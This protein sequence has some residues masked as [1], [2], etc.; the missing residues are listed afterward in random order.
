MTNLTSIYNKLTLK[1]KIGLGSFLM[2]FI[3]W[4]FCLP[5]LLFDDPISTVVLSSDQVLVGARIAEDGQWRFPELDSVPYRFEQSVLFFEDEYFYQHPGFNPVSIFKA[6][7]HNLTKDSRR[8]GSTITQQLIRLSRK[9]KSRTYWEKG[10]ELFLATRL[11][12]RYSKED[13]LRLYASHT[14]Y[15]GNV[16][17]LE[18][19]A[20]RYFGIPAHELSWGQSATLAVLPNAPSLIFPGRN[21]QTLR[22]KRNRL[23]KKLWVKDVIDQTTYELAIAE[24]LPQKPL[25]LPNIAPHLTER[26][27]KEHP[28]KSITTSLDRPL[29][30]QTNSLAEQH[31]QRLKSN[32]IHNLAILV[33][34]VETRKVLAYVGNSPASGEHGNYVD[35]I[36]KNRSTGSTLKPF[37]FTS[38]L[39]EGQLLPN[40][41]VND[42]PTVINGYNPKNFNK[43][44]TGVVPASWALSRSLNV[45]AVR[46]LRQ[47]G[48]QKFYNKLQK[49]QMKSLDKP[50][51]YYG[52]SLILGGA[53]SS[54]WDVTKSY[55]SAASTL[56]YF[57]SH[58]STYRSHEFSE[59]SY[60]KEQKTDFGKEQFEAPIFGAGAIYHTFKSLREVNR[61]EGDENW[62][63]F[64][65]A[66]PIAWKT[67]TSFGFK[68]AWAVGAT[69]KYAIGVWAGNADGEG[70]PGLVGISAAAPILFDVLASLPHSGWFPEP[71]DDLVALETCSKSG[72]RASVFCEDT[73]ELQLPANGFKSATCPY[74]HQ[75][76]LDAQESYRVTSSCYPMEDMVQK[77]WFSLPPAVE[78]YYADTNPNYKSLPPYLSGCG[79]EEQQLMEFIHPRLNEEIL[80]PKDLGTSQKDVVFKLAHQQEDSTVHWYLDETYVNTT[81]SFHELILPVKPGSY[82]L[83]AVD[84]GGNRIQQPIQV[85]L[86]SSQ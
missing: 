78:Y 15:G 38:L 73:Q 72:Q 47:F 23:L 19:A 66:Q 27:K 14:P 10:I 36:T 22:N 54:L 63:F 61:P 64:D 75:V 26:I 43:K 82:T 24:P 53:E 71:Y 83:T 33:L 69:P 11:E 86:A 2:L 30:I 21:E 50:A 59:P 67:G 32:E 4:L 13:I 1:H 44:H 51:E 52:L 16:V 6:I 68:D 55:A 76:F 81:T 20:W 18:T 49:M 9:N 65:A 8:G 35:I 80:I 41:L 31:Y 85:E 40:S 7:Q 3:I 5:K 37:L 42:I 70:R 34:D 29:Q 17:G 45:P 77:S 74:H 28:G 48:L 56:N 62:Q 60:L 46:L 25:P 84:D 12:L 39:H 57:V 58:S 79:S